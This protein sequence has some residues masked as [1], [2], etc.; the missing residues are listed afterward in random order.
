M[1][2]L[3]WVA[4]ILM[5]PAAMA[6]PASELPLDRPYSLRNPEPDLLVGEHRRMISSQSALGFIFPRPCLSF[7][8]SSRVCHES[9]RIGFRRDGSAEE[10]GIRP[11]IAEEFRSYGDETWSTEAGLKVWGRKGPAEFDLDGRMFVEPGGGGSAESFD[12]EDVD[13]QEDS[14]TGTISFRSYARFRGA[15]HWNTLVG[16]FSIARDAAQWGPGIFGNLTFNQNAVPFNQIRYQAD[17]GPITVISLYGDL[18]AGGGQA[19]SKENL[20][21]R[22]LYA[23]R[24]ELRCGSN[25]LLGLTDRLILFDQNKPYL[26]TPVFPL[27]MAKAFMFEEAN[28]GDLSLD[29][30][31][32]VPEVGMLYGEFLLDDLESPSSLILKSYVQNKWALLLG[33]HL[34]KDIAGTKTGLVAEYSRVEP[35]VYT[36]FDANTSQA[37]NMDHPLGNPMGP[38]SQSIT[39]MAYAWWRGSLKG[40]LT[41]GLAWKGRDEGSGINDSYPHDGK[42]EKSFLAGDPAPRAVLE[43]GAT[44]LVGGHSFSLHGRFGRDPGIT[45]RAMFAY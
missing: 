19:Y 1:R 26:F 28:N 42:Q 23:H 45:G 21:E 6:W 40:S 10:L 11:L 35:W 24:Y 32:R 25:L 39:A 27:F 9:Y 4:S 43:P 41:G 33:F 31:Y 3:A 15:M 34:A 12:R 16:R 13:L 2:G 30:T 7:V 5:L 20:R 29:A 36:H 38:N 17:L 14:V 18:L 22:N 37:A 44:W 8:D